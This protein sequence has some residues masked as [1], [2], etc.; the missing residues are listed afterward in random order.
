MS[1]TIGRWLQS[2]LKAVQAV[3]NYKHA[4]DMLIEQDPPDIQ[5]RV[6]KKWCS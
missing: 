5:C 6:G 4:K 1:S 3:L 2:T